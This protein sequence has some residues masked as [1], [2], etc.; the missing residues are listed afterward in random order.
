MGRS[1]GGEDNLKRFLVFY[2]AGFDPEI[3]ARAYADQA[4]ARATA[5][6]HQLR[7]KIVDVSGNDP[8]KQFWDSPGTIECVT[9]DDATKRDTSTNPRDSEIGQMVDWLFT[10]GNLKKFLVFY[11][12]GFDPEGQARAYSDRAAARATA[13]EKSIHSKIVD[14]AGSDP[15]KKFWDSLGTIECVT[16]DNGTKK[17]TSVNPSDG[18]INQMVDAL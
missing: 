14:T 8:D 12:A 16:V 2:R 3:Q 1:R 7:S 15:D 4:S 13:T 5:G 6:G 10:G 18:E 11:K 17:D 9:V